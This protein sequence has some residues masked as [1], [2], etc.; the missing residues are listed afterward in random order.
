[1]R[2]FSEWV[3]TTRDYY[4]KAIGQLEGDKRTLDP[5]DISLIAAASA[6]VYT[7]LREIEV[8]E[9]EMLK[10]MYQL[11]GNDWPPEKK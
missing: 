8:H 2:A 4:L 1:M 3:T 11:H 10:Q 5:N 6:V 7:T 9:S